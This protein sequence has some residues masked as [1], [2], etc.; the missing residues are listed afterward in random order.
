MENHQIYMQRA[1]GLAGQGRGLTYPNPLVGAVIV[2]NGQIIG[3]GWHRGPGQAHAEVDAL[4]HCKGNAQ[5]ATL[6]VTLEPCNH[7]GRTPP[8]TAAIIAAGITTV[9][10]A[11]PDPNPAVAGR[12]AE[13]LQ[14]AGLRVK[15]GLLK[16][17]ALALNRMFFHFC[18][19]GRP[20]VILK[21]ALSLDAKITSAGGDS[22]WITGEPART[23]VH[24]LRAASGA[25]LIGK[26]TLQADDPL[27]T[28]R[29]A[30]PVPR[31]PLKILLDRRLTLAVNANIVRQA[32]RNLLVF[33]NRS[34]DPVKIR[35]LS[36]LGVQVFPGR[37][38]EEWTLTQLIS[39]LGELGVQSLL[40]EGGS[41]VYSAFI[42]ADLVDEYYLFYAPFFMGG[43]GA[44]PLLDNPGLATVGVARRLKIA[45]VEQVGGD[46]LIRAY[47]EELTQC[48]P[49]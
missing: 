36:E 37:S 12:G 46:V 28:S 32:P 39:V 27:L 9:Y 6:Y 34:A 2:K 21:A 42:T 35:A 14:A 8:C 17:E 25:V 3:E 11:V 5:G 13:R 4:A 31:Q 33:C 41:K 44:L 7:Y 45:A 19:T 1:L 40:V 24:R 22:K 20:W 18:L 10:Y 26:G 48:L 16:A 38:G 29:L 43:G 15:A 23:R 30:G 49:V 47:K